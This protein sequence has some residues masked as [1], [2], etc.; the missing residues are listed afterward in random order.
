M[1]MSVYV[2]RQVLATPIPISKFVLYTLRDGGEALGVLIQDPNEILSAWH[3]ALEAADGPNSPDRRW[4]YH[5]HIS[6]MYLKE[7]T[8]HDDILKRLND[9]L[10]DQSNAPTVTITSVGFSQ[11]PTATVHFHCDVNSLLAP[12]NSSTPTPVIRFTRNAQAPI[13]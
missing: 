7:G 1:C 12:E 11:H 6:L 2:R 10:S 4:P 9:M 3:S 8:V 5:P 13:V